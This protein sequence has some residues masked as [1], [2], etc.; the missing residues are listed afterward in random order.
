MKLFTDEYAELNK[1]RAGEP[2]R[3][4]DKDVAERFFRTVCR[5][6]IHQEE[7][8]YQ[9]CYTEISSYWLPKHHRSYPQEL[10]YGKDGQPCCRR[11]TVLLS[12]P[13]ENIAGV[14]FHFNTPVLFCLCPGQIEDRCGRLVQVRKGIGAFGSD[15]YF[16]RRNDGSLITG[17]N[18]YLTKYY[19]Y[20]APPEPCDSVDTE[21]T[22]SPEARYPEKGFV[23]DNPS[24]PPAMVQSFA[25]TITE[26]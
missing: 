19:G 22:V 24:G 7:D 12:S 10:Q 9:P 2:F 23:I 20:V 3:P 14:K 11:K 5:G 26:A 18:L 13:Y 8:R 25:I 16:L 15:L 6:C 21:Y 4:A 1:D 17:E